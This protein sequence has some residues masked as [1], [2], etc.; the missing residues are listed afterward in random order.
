MHILLKNATVLNDGVAKKTNMIIE[1]STIVAIGDFI[2][3]SGV[4]KTI[5]LQNKYLVIPGFV[6]VHVHLRQPG[7]SYKETIKTG[8]LAAASA[9][10]TAICAMPNLDPVPDS[11]DNLQ[12]EQDI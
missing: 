7:F 4:E 8:S 2:S 12:V 5:D 1:G 3:L 9:G 11:I 10:Y 6:D